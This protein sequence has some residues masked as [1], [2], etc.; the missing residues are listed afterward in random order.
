MVYLAILS[1]VGLLG[2][3]LFFRFLP[4]IQTK[5][6]ANLLGFIELLITI[7]IGIGW[8]G[9]FGLYRVGLGYDTFAHFSV[10]MLIGLV[11]LSV[12]FVLIPEIQHSYF[13][14]FLIVAVLASVAG[15]INELFE[16]GGDQL[17]GTVM[18]GEAGQSD[19]TLRD[20]VGNT[21]G[22]LAGSVIGFATKDRIIDYVKDT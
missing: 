10:S 18:Y 4:R 20:L 9:G 8:L 7:G 11:I 1:S 3:W 6:T 2:P 16:Y 21:L 13:M 14:G 22:F 15:L 12:S 5:G 17:F 19:D